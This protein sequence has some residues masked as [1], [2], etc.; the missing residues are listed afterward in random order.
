MDPWA[1]RLTVDIRSDQSEE[2]MNFKSSSN[3]KQVFGSGKELLRRVIASDHDRFRADHFT[4]SFHFAN[5]WEPISP[6]FEH[7]CKPVSI[8]RRNLL[9]YC[10]S[11]R[12]FAVFLILSSS[13]PSF[14]S[15]LRICPRILLTSTGTLSSTSSTSYSDIRKFPIHYGGFW[16][17]ILMYFMEISIVSNVDIGRNLVE[18]AHS[19]ESPGLPSSLLFSFTSIET[20]LTLF[21]IFI[22][23]SIRVFR[24]SSIE[25]KFRTL[26]CTIVVVIEC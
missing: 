19:C 12:R 3:R 8:I 4:A 22:R 7:R 2:V 11:V 14:V 23:S 26:S 17:A 9:K 10:D 21:I 16:H 5:E 20:H 15:R 13:V 24:L 18:L 6:Y 25:T 1:N